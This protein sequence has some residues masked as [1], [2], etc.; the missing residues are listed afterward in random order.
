MAEGINR[1]QKMMRMRARPK[2][3][4]ATTYEEGLALYERYRDD[5]LGV[6]LD[7]SLPRAGKTG[8]PRPASTSLGMLKARMPEIPVLIQSGS[9]RAANEAV[10]G[11]QV[12]DK[13]SPNLLAEL[14][15][16]IQNQLGFGEFAFRSA[17]GRWSSARAPD[18]RSL[19]WAIQAVPGEAL[20]STIEPEGSR[21]VADG[22]DRIRAGGE[23]PAPYWRRTR[24]GTGENQE[25]PARVLK[26]HRDKARAGVV[27]EF[28]AGE[29]RRRPGLRPHRDRLPGRKG[30]GA[31]L[32]QLP[33]R[34]L[35][36]GAPLRRRE[37]PCPPTAVLA[38][39][40]FDQFMEASGLLALRPEETDDDAITEAF[41]QAELPG[42]G[43]GQPL[44][45]PGL[46]ALPAGRA[47]LQP[48]RGRLVP[49]L[50]G[51][52]RNLHDPQQPPATRRSRLEQL[53]R[54]IKMVYASTYHSDA[55]AY[56]ESTPN[57]LEEEKMAVVIQQVVGSSHGQYLYPDV[58][59]VAR[60]L[61]YYPM[62][63][64]KPEDGVASVAL[65][66]GKTVVDGGR[67]TRFCPAQPRKPLQC[68][69]PR[70]LP[71]KRPAHLHWPWT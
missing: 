11:V 12:V 16:F 55:K 46:G 57:R 63:G 28:S 15:A 1:M 22:P 56:I 6:I 34:L 4:L 23:R 29:L 61:N 51:D 42:G 8:P 60:S 54:A 18:L 39:G 10:A 32:H 70:G 27:A 49:A 31:G 40:V 48:P 20:T 69:S 33:H 7:A 5:L 58:A 53:C 36:A 62:P 68:F 64:M 37:D 13:N 66:F 59:G 41:L 17:R 67:C 14:R 19:E 30:E 71:G 43:R 3:L 25:R 24:R 35:R 21:G 26:A 45:L 2:I 44:D 9:S 65:G 38:T 47:V 50:R 52:L